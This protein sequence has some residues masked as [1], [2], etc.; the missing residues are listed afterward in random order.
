LFFIYLFYSD[1][2]L[3]TDTLYNI[4]EINLNKRLRLMDSR[5]FIV[6]SPLA[7]A[8]LWALFNIGRAAIQQ[9]RRLNNA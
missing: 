8:A 3:L 1:D 4:K 5:I 9:I 6:F 2:F 7:I